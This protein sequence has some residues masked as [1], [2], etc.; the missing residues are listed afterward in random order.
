MRSP[1]CAVIRCNRF[2]VVLEAMKEWEGAWGV[3][4]A[5]NRGNGAVIPAESW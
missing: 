1:I 5:G 2:T 3:E 4:T